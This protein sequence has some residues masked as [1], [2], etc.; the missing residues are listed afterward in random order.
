M[1]GDLLEKFLAGTPLSGS[2]SGYV[3]AQYEEYLK[4]PQN[5]EESWRNYFDSFVDR[6]TPDVAHTPI[7]ESFVSLAQE[8]D[9]R[10]RRGEGMAPEAATKQAGVLR[11]INYYR[12]RGHQAADLDPLGLA[13]KPFFRDLDPAFHGLGEQDMDTEFNTGSLVGEERMK[14]RDIIALC[15]DVYTGSIG[16]EYMYITETAEKRWI[17]QRLEGH[18]FKSKLEPAERST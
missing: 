17:Q 8:R 11:L 10:K 3:D 2:H 18:A 9:R 7:R 12:V 15:R 5:V 16:A 4:N 6:T 1:R 13:E 14:L